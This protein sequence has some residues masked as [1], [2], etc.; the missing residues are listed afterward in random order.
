LGSF[1][2]FI[3]ASTTLLAWVLVSELVP[4]IPGSAP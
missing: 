3:M 1:G 2:L 4:V